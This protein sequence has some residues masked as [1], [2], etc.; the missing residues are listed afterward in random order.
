MNQ[1]GRHELVVV[2]TAAD[3]AREAARIIAE[4]L[5]QAQLLAR[6]ELP[7]A[8]EPQ[9]SASVAFSGG[10]SPKLLFAA[11]LEL[12]TQLDWSRIDLFQV[13]ERVAPDGDPSRNLV[14]LQH[15]LLDHLNPRA[16][17]HPIP[18]E[19]GAA[20]A[21]VH[22]ADTISRVLGSG[23]H[24]DVVH[25]GLGND[26][27]CASLVPGDQALLVVDSDTATTAKYQGHER[28]TMTYRML[29]RA[30]CVVWLVTGASK[31]SALSALLREDPAIPAAHVRPTRS[32]IVADQSALSGA[33]RSALSGADR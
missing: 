8:Q 14:D 12:Q 25:L 32:I 27:H 31:R 29:N 10:S 19:A 16:L 24:L 21:A 28:V 5:A 1:L 11:L 17:L 23:A 9:G 26:G 3:A 13:D 18:V 7:H 20:E 2:R 6:D 33:D 15:E 4:L 22:Y 30:R